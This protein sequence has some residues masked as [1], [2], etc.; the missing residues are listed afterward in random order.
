MGNTAN[1][2]I[3][4]DTGEYFAEI[5]AGWKMLL[6]CLLGTATGAAVIPLY[7]FG[8]FAT[9]LISEFGWTQ[10]E[11]QL[12]ATLFFLI[13]VVSNLL[14]GWLIRRTSVIKLVVV[15]TIAYPLTLALLSLQNGSLLWFYINYGVLTLAGL[16]TTLITWSLITNLR[17]NKARG[18]ALAILLSGTGLT[19][20]TL[21]AYT[22]L[23]IELMGWRLAYIAVGLLPLLLLL[24]AVIV[25]RKELGAV[26]IGRTQIRATEDSA[27]RDNSRENHFTAT[28]SSLRQAFLQYRFWVL[29]AVIFPYIALHVGILINLIPIL[30]EKGMPPLE[31][32]SLAGVYGV[33]LTVGRLAAGY[34]IDHYWAPMIAFLAM[35]L[36]AI[37][38]YL[39]L[40]DTSPAFLILAISLIGIAG[41]V[42]MDVASFLVVKYF[43]LI[44]YPQIYAVLM[45]ASTLGAALGP[46]IFGRVFDL[47]G[48]YDMGITAAMLVFGLSPSLLLTLGKYPRQW[49]AS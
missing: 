6:L 9:S 20:M 39:L 2:R 3:I 46:L 22:T 16:G 41:G 23:A 48:S 27:G 47:T 49:K 21:P 29:I 15:S 26:T 36:P 28:G 43:G 5:R 35:T 17:F 19:A 33:A 25:M 18:L 8:A 10:A 14:C 37:A 7:C 38:C 32:A 42:E 30:T 11:L 44:H 40:Q 34:L 1:R 12:A 24:P 31:A 13:L 4:G 45:S